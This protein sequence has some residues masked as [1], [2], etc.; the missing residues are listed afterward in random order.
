MNKFYEKNSNKIILITYW[1]MIL[2]NFIPFYFSGLVCWNLYILLLR[3]IRIVERAFIIMQLAHIL[4]IGTHVFTQQSLLYSVNT[5][6][7]KLYSIHWMKLKSNL[8]K[9]FSKIKSKYSGL[10]NLKWTIN[11]TNR[12][13]VF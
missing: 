5:S 2:K 13:Y 4:I 12:K 10:E 6:L 11:N 3:G 1:K 9:I 8:F 7:E